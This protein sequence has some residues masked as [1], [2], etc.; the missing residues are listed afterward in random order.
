[1][2]TREILTDAARRPLDT[3]AVLLKGIDVETLNAQPAPGANSISWLVW[4]AAR[5][6]DVQ[7]AELTGN[8]TVWERNGWARQ[9]GVERG[10]DDFGFG[11]GPE[12][13]AALRIEDPAGLEALLTACVEDLVAHIATLS[14]ED[15]DEIVDERWDPP[16]SR[17][18]RIVSIID[19]AV[20]HLG[21]ASYARGLV[22]GWK[23]GV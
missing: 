19:D 2:D 9:L 10:A 6:M 7:L 23:L 16:V 21:Q 18:V 17:G 4:H 5:Q 14:A 3:A 12:Q 15:L 1:M 22:E 20:V 13:V 8:P 11:D